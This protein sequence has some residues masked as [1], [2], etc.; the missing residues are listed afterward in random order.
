MWKNAPSIMGLRVFVKS[1]IAA[2]QLLAL[3]KLIEKNYL[4]IDIPQ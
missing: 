2:L 4:D 1:L 3:L